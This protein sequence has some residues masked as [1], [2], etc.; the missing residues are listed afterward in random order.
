MADQNDVNHILPFERDG[1]IVTRQQGYVKVNEQK[2]SRDWESWIDQQIR[3]A[4]E[5]GAFDNLPGRGRPIDLTPNPYAQDREMAFKILKD[6]GYAPDWLELDKAIRGKLDQAR[7]SLAR[8]WEWRQAR[9]DELADHTD[10]WG[11]AERKRVLAGWR[12]AV[13]TFEEQVAAINVEISNLNLKVPAPRFQRGQIDAAHEVARLK[14]GSPD[15]DAK[16]SNAQERMAEAVR[17]V[18][19]RRERA[20]RSPRMERALKRLIWRYTRGTAAD[21]DEQKERV[22]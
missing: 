1:R 4:Q 14:A 17:Q 19:T 8:S 13:V 5:R 18:V 6:A 2:S 3:E 15:D 22:D 9:L 7:A 20:P 11:V 10:S 21:A 12:Q 16:A